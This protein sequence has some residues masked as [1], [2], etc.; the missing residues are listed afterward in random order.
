[1]PPQEAICSM[2]LDEPEKKHED[3]D[4]VSGMKRHNLNDEALRGYLNAPSFYS[5]DKSLS[6]KNDSE[7]CL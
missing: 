4:A 3:H 6:F 5:V 1:M 7:Y 2:Q